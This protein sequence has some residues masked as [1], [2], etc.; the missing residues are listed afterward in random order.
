METRNK[1]QKLPQNVI[2]R[3]AAGKIKKKYKIIKGEVIH[4]PVNVV[5]ELIENSIDAE[6]TNI[7]ITLTDGGVRMIKIQDNGI[8]IH[9][10]DLEM[11]C[12]RHTTSKLTKFEQLIGVNSYGFRGEALASISIVS[13]I[14]VLTRIKNEENYGYTVK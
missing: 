12:E 14:T 5:K 9:K 13:K 2:D 11:L 3:I 7:S 10:N 6:S 4:R 8:G 1:I